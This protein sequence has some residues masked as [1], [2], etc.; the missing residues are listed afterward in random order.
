[1]A[2]VYD[3]YG[4]VCVRHGHCIDSWYAINAHDGHCSMAIM[5]TMIERGYDES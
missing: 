2:T 5:V 1:M 3:H 4:T